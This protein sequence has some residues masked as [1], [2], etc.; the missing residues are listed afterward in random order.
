M[1]SKVNKDMFKAF[2]KT[3]CE[4][5]L[6]IHEFILSFLNNCINENLPLFY[7]IYQY[8]NGT[9][10]Y[11]DMTFFSEI[12]NNGDA[13]GINFSENY[14]DTYIYVTIYSNTYSTDKKE[15]IIVIP[16]NDYLEN[17]MRL[18]NEMKTLLNIATWQENN[19]N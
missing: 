15:T 5:D 18:V 4:I 8:R 9:I 11:D 3:K 19:K 16:V 1:I 14:N 10:A 2:M 7:Q 12:T 6:S 13:S 17:S